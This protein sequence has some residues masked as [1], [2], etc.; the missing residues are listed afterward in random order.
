VALAQTFH[1]AIAG[2]AVD[3]T[4]GAIA[5]ASVRAVSQETGFVYAS[6][7]GESGDYLF[8]NLPPGVYSATFERTGFQTLKVDGL[9]VSAARTTNYVAT[10][11]VAQQAAAIEVNADAATLET[12]SSGLVST[13]DRRQWRDLPIAN[14]NFRNMVRLS[15]GVQVAA[16]SAAVNG[17]RPITTNFQIDGADNNDSF[18]NS[19][20][21]GGSQSLLPME[22]IDQ[23]SLVTSGSAEFGRNSGANVSLVTK[24][25]GNSLHGSLFYN[26]RNEVFATHTPFQNPATDKK[27]PIRQH[28]WGGSMGGAIVRNR[29][30]YFT[31]VEGYQ[32]SVRTPT[33]STHPSTAWVNNARAVMQRYGV[34]MNPVAESL[35]TLWPSEANGA[36]A[37][38]NNMTTINPNQTD[39]VS[40]LIKL[41]YSISPKHTLSSRYLGTTGN[42]VVAAPS[43]YT[44]FLG[45][46]D[47]RMHNF[48]V[49]LNSAL[50]PRLMNQLILGASYTFYYVKEQDPGG[51]PIAAGLN[52]GVS[53]TGTLRGLP[54]LRISNFAQLGRDSPTGRA[55][56]TGHIT[57]HL[58]YIVGRHTLKLGGEYRRQDNNVFFY[59]NGRGTFAWDGTRGPWATDTSVSLGL[60]AL[61]DFLAGTPTNNSGAVIV[62]GGLERDY[63]HNLGDWWLQDHWQVNS[64]LNLNYGV[65]WSYV[66]P[67]RDKQDKITSFTLENGFER[68]GPNG[69]PLWRKDY[70]NFA[71]RLGFAYQAVSR[72]VVRGG[73]GIYYDA[74]ASNS[75]V[76]NLSMPNG[77]ADGIHANPA[78]PDPVFTI[79]QPN[80]TFAANQPVFP[81]NATPRSVGAFGVNKDWR[82]GYL[83]NYHLHVQARLHSGVLAQV[84]YVGSHGTAL[85]LLRSV[86]PVVGGRRL[87]AD[88]YP[89]LAAIN[90][91][92]TAG[93]SNYNSLQASLRVTSWKRLTVNANYT[94]AKSLD[95]GPGA[96]ST[97]PANSF[98]LRR[99]Y[100]PSGFDNRHILTGLVNHE[101][102]GWGARLPL[103]TRGWQVNS[104][105]T[106]HTGDPL[107]L[108]SGTNRSGALDNRDRVDVVGDW[109]TGIPARASS[110]APVP[111]FNP[112][113]F[114]AAA[115][116]TFGNIGR[117]ALYGPGMVNID[118]SFF[119]EFPIRE[120]LRTQFRVEIYNLFNR[121]N[122]GNPGVA[123]NAPAS[124]GL[125]S[126][127]RTEMRVV[128]LALRLHW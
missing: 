2:A 3:A 89:L 126:T 90:I 118:F 92:E 6:Q 22:A 77:G 29:F 122:W 121:A 50:S 116:G 55:L 20:S 68:I 108:L 49:N 102:P 43:P 115:T 113:A 48:A 33:V 120:N 86:N 112:R 16:A 19:V 42:Q 59:V 100:G 97:L 39:N 110:F 99:E 128:Q 52:T 11:T 60:R 72:L 27:R 70:N 23:M 1:G 93:N 111:W 28:L 45:S 13:L 103:L 36:P 46:N 94:Y 78:G 114:A 65:R 12:T 62:R 9:Q 101:L 26:N 91:Q 34:A 79:S 7:T 75:F 17:S 24:S 56:W 80:V 84:G 104:L 95:N 64:K 25:G 8:A 107:D 106:A 87:H 32:T 4:G 41:D 58:A 98:N 117:N 124:F 96:R 44:P 66:G 30:F 88:R 15:P 21:A 74:P 82:L 57:N 119:K 71:P 63:L 18:F 10:L 83:Q 109:R 85:P 69:V 105:F 37:V 40:G 54:A 51:N 127:T 5:G 38:N 31:A 35:L 76:A 125:I 73:Y 123:L 14:R 81:T 53:Q 61:S 67:F 47:T